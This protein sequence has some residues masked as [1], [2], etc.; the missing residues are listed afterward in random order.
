MPWYKIANYFDQ[1]QS[2]RADGYIIFLN[3]NKRVFWNFFEKK[4]YLEKDEISRGRLSRATTRTDW[5]AAHGFTAANDKSLRFENGLQTD[6][7]TFGFGE[8]F[9]KRLFEGVFLGIPQFPAYSDY[10]A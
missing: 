9:L 3:N 2:P 1:L 4:N 6:R 8:L 5:A 10:V 7:I